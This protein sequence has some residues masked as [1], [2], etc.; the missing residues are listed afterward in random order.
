M[1][2]YDIFFHTS[3]TFCIF[4]TSNITEINKII[5]PTHMKLAIYSVALLALAS[6]SCSFG[7]HINDSGADLTTKRITLTSEVTS[8]EVSAGMSVIYEA[9]VDSMF[10]E[11]TSPTDVIEYVDIDIDDNILEISRDSKINSGSLPRTV[12]RVCTPNLYEFE[13]SSGSTLVVS[14]NY[15]SPRH[16]VYAECSSGATLH[17][18]NITATELCGESSSGATMHVK[19]SCEKARLKASSGATLD[20]LSLKATTGSAKASSG[21][22]IRCNIETNPEISTSSGGSIRND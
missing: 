4:A 3:A 18:D 15:V 11:I 5:I 6:C 9:G 2:K 14:G 13:A 16:T 22:S 7:K 17:I 12:V 1:Q 19:G 20:A 21:A 8:I 10:V